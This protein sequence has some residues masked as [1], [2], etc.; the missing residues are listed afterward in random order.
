MPFQVKATVVRFLG[1]EEKY[2]CHFQHRVGDEFIYDGEKYLGTICPSMAR[3]LIPSMM[4][5]HAAGPRVIPPSG[6][7]YPF[8]YSSLSRK[9]PELK[10]YD[11]LGFQNVLET[12]VEAQYHAAN[13]FPPNANK[14]PPHPERTVC[15]ETS[16]VVCPDPRTLMVMKM[17][18]FD[19]SDKGYDVP[20]FR[21]EMVIL[22]RV[23]KKEGIPTSSILGEFSKKEI[24]D[25]YPALSQ[26]MVDCL[27]EELELMGY[28]KIKGGK[29]SVHVKGRKKLESFKSG[30]P[31]EAR[32]ALKV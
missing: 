24:E 1:D 16:T 26:I 14:W 11:G 30:L 10:K 2:P 19:L 9:A 15:K 20:Y 22:D 18:A 25:I 29:A 3:F 21:R 6:Y 4:P 28:L 7:Y 27:I 13:Q 31:S 8:W 23:L 5:L 12:A 17:E 32:K